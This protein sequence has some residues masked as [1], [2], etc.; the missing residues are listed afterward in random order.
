MTV[1]FLKPC[2]GSSVGYRDPDSNQTLD[3]DVLGKRE[4]PVHL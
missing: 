1:E 3:R 2:T 4:G